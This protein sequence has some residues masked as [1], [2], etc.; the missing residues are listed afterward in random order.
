VIQAR[1]SLRPL[2]RL[3]LTLGVVALVILGLGLATI[4]RFAPPGQATGL[5]VRILGVYPYDP[6]QRSITDGPSTH[7][8]RTQA[9][10]ARVDWPAL[11]GSV[12]AGAHWYNTL[13]EPV[14][15]VG[16][17]PVRVLAGADAVVPVMTPPDLH[18]NL[19]GDYSLVVARYSR[20]QPVELLGRTVV[21][22]ERG[23]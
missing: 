19:P 13:G 14:G 18:A 5:K 4:F 20:G 21:L 17:A 10:A 23:G 16:P 22:V 9:F 7:F 8:A 3:M 1:E 15:G 11:P 6:V 2:F 12:V